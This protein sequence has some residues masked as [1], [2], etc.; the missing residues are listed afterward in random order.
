[1]TWQMTKTPYTVRDMN[2]VKGHE[3]DPKTKLT[4]QTQRNL[5]T[6]VADT[7]VPYMCDVTSMSQLTSMHLLTVGRVLDDGSCQQS[8]PWQ[9][10]QCRGPNF[11]WPAA[12]RISCCA[13]GICLDDGYVTTTPAMRSTPR[14]GN[15]SPTCTKSC[16]T[17]TRRLGGP[18]TTKH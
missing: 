18:D 8:R 5:P 4:L 6:D 7:Q 15:H 13:R 2:P 10:Q 1:M 12:D 11:G 16:Y 14:H 3:I 17:G 9:I